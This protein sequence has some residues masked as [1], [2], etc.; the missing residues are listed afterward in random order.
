MRIGGSCSSPL[1]SLHLPHIR[2][3]RLSYKVSRDGT[4]LN[5]E[6]TPEE[7]AL[8]DQMT[9]LELKD[10]MTVRWGRD[11]GRGARGILLLTSLGCMQAEV[12]KAQVAAKSSQYR[13]V[14]K[15]GTSWQA[16]SR[17]GG[18]AYTHGTFPISDPEG[19]EKAARMYDQAVIARDG[20][21]AVT[22]FWYE[23]P[24]GQRVGP[25]DRHGRHNACTTPSRLAHDGNPA[26]PQGW[27]GDT[28]KRQS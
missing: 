20:A 15:A 4:Q 25:V 11:G 26:A 8:L 18:K 9:L 17:E 13:G 10:N 2:P 27:H 22:N 14:H 3:L 1:A 12:G 5:Y 19:E 7:K 28:S 16:V 21:A 6:L 24:G 23:L